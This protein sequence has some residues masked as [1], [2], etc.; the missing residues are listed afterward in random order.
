GLKKVG[1]GISTMGTGISTLMTPVSATDKDVQALAAK[2]LESEKKEEYQKLLKEAEELGREL[3]T[4]MAK[5]QKAQQIASSHTAGIAANL[6][7]MNALSQQAQSLSPVLDV[8]VKRH[9]KAMEARARDALRW[10]IYNV[11]MASRYEYLSLTDV[12]Q[13]FYNL[14]NM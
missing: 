4:V 11:I 10:S 14:E 5:F 13:S 7:E 6:E 8:R 9:L 2:M 12:D 3:A 1:D